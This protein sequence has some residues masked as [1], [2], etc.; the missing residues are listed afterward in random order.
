MN[1]PFIRRCPTCDREMYHASKKSRDRAVREKRACYTCA[2][3]ERCSRPEIKHKMSEIG[4]SLLGE[5]NP[6]FGKKHSAET[7]QKIIENTDRTVYKTNSF[8]QKMSDL[9]KGHNN[10]MAGR[11]A[12]DAM[13]AKYGKDE[14]EQKWLKIRSDKSKKMTGEGNHMYG[15]PAPRGSG[16]GWSGWYK[17]YYFRSLKELAYIL[18]LESENI[19]FVSAEKKCYSI[20]YID[21]LGKSRTYRADFF[22]GGLKL[23]EIKPVALQKT[24]INQ[25]KQQVAIEFCSKMGWTY[26]MV[27]IEPVPLAKLEELYNEDK[28]KLTSKW[29]TRLCSMKKKK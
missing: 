9:T 10:P 11:S 14:A 28:L 22:V 4:K 3:I 1:E 6:F 15:K 16:C 2:S 25:K 13:V 5:K 7:K 19:Q 24:L 8:R 29:K 23:V 18:K 20:A 21:D 27:D 12:F 17:S 26:E